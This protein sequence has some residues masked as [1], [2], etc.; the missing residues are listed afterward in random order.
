MTRGFDYNATSPLQA[1]V[2]SLALRGG[3]MFASV[4]GQPRGQ[5]DACCRNF[6][7]RVGIA[8][9]MRA[10]LVLRTGFGIF[11][12][13]TTT[14][15][16]GTAASPGFSVATPMVTSIDGI[17][18]AD[19]LSNPFPTGLLDP[20]GSAQGLLTLVGQSVSFTEV[21]RPLTYSELHHEL[22]CGA[23]HGQ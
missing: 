5:T 20:I 3:L 13:G 7:P 14:L 1:R 4:N 16:R 21:T 8:Y 9:Q 18:P 6:A 19:R 11:Y 15:G 10:K 22:V 17:T 12:S 23:D 2:Q